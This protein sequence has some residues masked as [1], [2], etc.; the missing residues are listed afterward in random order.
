[1]R[2][3][4]RNGTK[5]CA[6]NGGEGYC[7]GNSISYADLALYNALTVTSAIK[8]EYVTKHFPVVKRHMEAVESNPAVAAYLSSPNRRH[9]FEPWTM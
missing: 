6:K 1:M 2:L 9:T 8:A 4:K 7:L 5:L 3:S